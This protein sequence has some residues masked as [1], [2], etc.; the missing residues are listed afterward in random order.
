MPKVNFGL[1]R[2]LEEEDFRVL[3]ALE[4]C[5]R[6]HEVAPTALIERIA[7]LPRGGAKKRLNHLLKFKIIHHE[8][9]MY[10][11]YAMKYA[12]YDFLAMRTFTKRGTVVGVGSRIGCGKES[13]ILTVVDPQGVE[14][15]VKLQRL[16]RCSFRSVAR[17]RDYKGNQKQRHGESWFYLSRLAA[18]KEFAFMKLLYDE[19]FPVPKPIDHNRHAVVMERIDGIL[20]NNILDMGEGGNPQKVYERA[21]GL[22]VKLAQ[23]GL[24]HGDFNEFNMMITPD[25]RVIMIDFPQMVSTDHP[26]AD[27]LFDRDVENLA[28][29]FVRRF[30][31]EQTF[32]PKLE[33]DVEHV[34]KEDRFDQKLA[35]SGA[36]TK[37]QQK[38]MEQL[39]KQSE[40]E[41]EDDEDESED[42][43]AMDDAEAEK[44]AENTDDTASVSSDR[45]KRAKHVETAVPTI[46]ALAARA[47]AMAIKPSPAVPVRTDAEAELDGA[48]HETDEISSVAGDDTA[49]SVA[50]SIASTAQSV[51]KLILQKR[52]AAHN[53]NLKGDAVNKDHVWDRTKAFNRHLDNVAFNSTMHRNCQKG[54]A[55]QRVQRELHRG[56]HPTSAHDRDFD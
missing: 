34:Q 45:P 11:G 49:T 5:L 4:M 36:F 21:L 26:N 28:A 2:Y 7:Q 39:L 23:H 55:K 8:S 25:H 43:E 17:N 51:A 53:A 47:Q 3:T 22:M 40:L 29:F 41:V 1:V 19:G 24:I 14:S 31:I 50:Q 37:A 52:Q 32:F 12:A 44:L 15:V 6:N 38:E 9:L 35:A 27:E 42:D 56:E 16:G 48:A 20:L 46:A 54:K 13:D 18:T 10:E 33:K 30:K